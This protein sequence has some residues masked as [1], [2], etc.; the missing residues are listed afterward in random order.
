M[1]TTDDATSHGG[2]R[3]YG[4][5]RNERVEI[6]AQVGA[7]VLVRYVA[8][9]RLPR[10]VKRDRAMGERAAYGPLLPWAWLPA[11]EIDREVWG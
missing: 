11:R 3:M 6:Q 5:H 9:Q 1:S 10:R 7:L 4:W 8:R 2:A